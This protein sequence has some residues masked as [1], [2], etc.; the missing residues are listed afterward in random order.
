MSSH[1]RKYKKVVW[2]INFFPAS[3][4]L[5]QLIKEFSDNDINVPNRYGS[6]S[7]VIIPH[8][9]NLFQYKLVSAPGPP[10]LLYIRKRRD[11]SERGQITITFIKVG[12]TR[13]ETM[14][15][16]W[17]I[18]ADILHSNQTLSTSKVECEWRHGSSEAW[19]AVRCLDVPNYKLS[20][21]YR[22]DE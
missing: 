2:Y 20:E 16:N 22:S 12:S 19:I 17:L 13:R 3:K 4:I 6:G 9:V 15:P 8:Y 18:F 14:R 5:S 10:V 21:V 7:R 11:N 1:R